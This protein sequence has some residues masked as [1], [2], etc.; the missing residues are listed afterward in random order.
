MTK[1]FTT[2]KICPKIF[3]LSLAAEADTVTA[4]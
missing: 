2:D 1:I 4:S 3:E